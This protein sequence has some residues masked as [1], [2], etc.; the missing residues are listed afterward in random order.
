MAEVRSPPAR[1]TCFPYPLL[2][3]QR[4]IRT[5]AQRACLEIYH[6]EVTSYLPPILPR[7]ARAR[8][9]TT[10]MPSVHHGIGG[11]RRP[12]NTCPARAWPFSSRKCTPV[13]SPVAALRVLICPVRRREVS[14]RSPRRAGRFIGSH[15]CTRALSDCALNSC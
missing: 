1:T 8:S 11:L 10:R 7:L 4:G 14:T 12:R 5:A 13:G 15:E 3:W 9:G 2:M 6:D